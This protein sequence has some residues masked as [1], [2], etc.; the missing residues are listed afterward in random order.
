MDE[1]IREV[2]SGEGDSATIGDFEFI[3]ESTD[4]G[5]L[6]TISCKEKGT[7]EPFNKVIQLQVMDNGKL[8]LRKMKNLNPKVFETIE[9]GKI[10]DL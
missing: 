10:K 4:G 1:E 6:V 5:N 3:A 9:G 7:D 8:S 2:D